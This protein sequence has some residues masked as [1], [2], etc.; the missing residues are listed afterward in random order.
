MEW[1]IVMCWGRKKEVSST[2]ID[3]RYYESSPAARSSCVVIFVMAI[4]A[5]TFVRS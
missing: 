2:R 5:Q 1:I 4:T 3:P